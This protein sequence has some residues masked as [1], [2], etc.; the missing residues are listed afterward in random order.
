[1]AQFAKKQRLSRDFA[2]RSFTNPALLREVYNR[3][4]QS[5]VGGTSLDLIGCVARMARCTR[6]SVC[7]P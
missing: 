4:I 2:A 6:V 7:N 1:M 5:L 3:L